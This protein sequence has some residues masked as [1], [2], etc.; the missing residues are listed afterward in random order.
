M[1]DDADYLMLGLFVMTFF[2]FFFGSDKDSSKA[3][4]S[5]TLHFFD[6]TSGQVTFIQKSIWNF[7]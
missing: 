2:F 1:M 3:F 6:L 4:T 7:D 5:L